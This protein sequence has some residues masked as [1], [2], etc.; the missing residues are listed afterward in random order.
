[1]SAAML[2]TLAVAI[3]ALAATTPLA[4]AEPLT[5]GYSDWPGWVAFEVAIQKGWYKEAGVDVSFQWMEYAPAMDAFA[6]G[7]LDATGMTNGDALVYGANGTKGKCILVTDYSNGN[8][9]IIGK[10]GINSVKDLK[11]KKVGVELTLVDHLLLLKAL[12]LNGMKESDVTLVGVATNDTPQTL[13]SGSVDAV[14]CWYPVSGIALAQ[15]PGS[16]P[17]FT[18]KDVPGLIYDAIYVHPESLVAR[19]DDWMKFMSVWPRIIDYIADPKTQP[20]AMK[21]MAARVG[22]TP[23]AYTK[24]AMGTYLL[25]I[26]DNKKH[27]MPGEGLDT[28]LGST[29]I[30]NWFNEKNTVYKPGAAGDLA[31]YFDTTFLDAGK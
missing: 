23:A 22:T 2:R 7:K 17:L 3:V 27:L 16:K 14:C 10:P 31:A 13:A 6:A 18:S 19:K 25:S 30:A 1:M 26:A 28:L 21:I 15:V 12:E 11:G 24:G 29:K 4:A 5:I 20:D 9:M 8:D